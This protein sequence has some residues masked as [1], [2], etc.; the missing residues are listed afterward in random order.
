MPGP[1]MFSVLRKRLLLRGFIVSDFAAKQARF[2]ARC[3]RMG[4]HG[5][6]LGTLT[7][8]RVDGLEQDLVSFLGLVQGQNFGKSCW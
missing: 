1:D 3:R 2:P 7:G 5:S 8:A 4:S 6:P